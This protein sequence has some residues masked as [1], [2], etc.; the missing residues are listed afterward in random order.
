MNNYNQTELILRWSK[1][2]FALL[3][4]IG[5]IYTGWVVSSILIL[6][7]FNFYRLNHVMWK[8]EVLRLEKSAKESN[9]IYSSWNRRNRRKFDKKIKR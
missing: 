2:L 3:S 8:K 5:F 1:N 6:L 4:I 7:S 9:E